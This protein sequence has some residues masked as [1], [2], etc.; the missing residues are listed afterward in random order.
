MKSGYQ[1]EIAALEFRIADLRRDCF[2]P[3]RL[4]V[5][6][7]HALLRKAKQWGAKLKTN[8]VSKKVV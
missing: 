6:R 3:P 4:A 2:V 5:A 7:P 8:A 1:E